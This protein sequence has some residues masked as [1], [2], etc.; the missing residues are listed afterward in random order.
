MSKI[1]RALEEEAR[2]ARAEAESAKAE[3][4]VTVNYCYTLN[5]RASLRPVDPLAYLEWL[6]LV[7]RY[8]WGN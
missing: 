3:P 8:E 4:P 1:M 2:Q 7:R 6:A 5:G